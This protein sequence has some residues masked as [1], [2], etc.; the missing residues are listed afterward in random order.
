[1]LTVADQNC[2]SPLG[3]LFE[4]S[5]QS[6]IDS[7]SSRTVFNGSI[8]ILTRLESIELPASLQNVIRGLS[9]RDPTSLKSLRADGLVQIDTTQEN[10][11]VAN[12][13]GLTFQFPKLKSMAGNFYVKILIEGNT[14]LTDITG[15]P[16][17]ET[18]G[19]DAEIEG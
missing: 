19:G 13:P 6:N 4:I 9:A 10:F 15:F 8:Q 1:M 16:T 17:L 2:S 3:G 12:I 18:I 11:V 5:A 14:V 7:I